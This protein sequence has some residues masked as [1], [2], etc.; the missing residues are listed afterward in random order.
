MAAVVVIDEDVDGGPVA[1]EVEERLVDKVDN[2]N[3]F[4][5]VPIVLATF[6]VDKLDPIPMLLF[7]L[8]P[9]APPDDKPRFGYN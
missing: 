1:P 5:V 2:G 3:E 9:A 7:S 4:A 8:D 6:A